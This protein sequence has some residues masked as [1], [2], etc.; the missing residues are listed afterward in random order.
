M[1]E[2]SGPSNYMKSLTIVIPT[3]NRK[4]RLLQQLR[5]ILSQPLSNTVDVLICD[6]CSNY[7]VEGEIRREFPNNNNVLVEHNKY[8]IGGD[9]NIASTFLKC[10]TTWMWLLGDDDVTTENSI[11]II[12]NDIDSRSNIA[13]IKYSIEGFASHKDEIVGNLEELIDCYYYQKYTGGDLIFISNNVY[14]LDIIGQYFRNTLLQCSCRISQLLP[15]FYMMQENGGKALI[16]SQS[17]VKYQKP[18]KGTEWNMIDVS[19]GIASIPYLQLNID[20][21][22]YRRLMLK[23]GEG[24]PHGTL[25]KQCLQLKRQDQAKHI[26][27]HIYRNIFKERGGLKDVCYYIAFH[28]LWIVRLYSKKR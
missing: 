6:N 4:E 10:K 13:F 16:S 24:F 7:D 21:K 9:A 23:V 28:I 26:Y 14:N 15:L 12:L 18:A 17:I 22:H 27:H 1:P 8:N 2:V 25:V 19:V 5:S 11:E 20:K 3:Y